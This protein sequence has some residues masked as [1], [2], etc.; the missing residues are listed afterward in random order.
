MSQLFRALLIALL[1]DNF[2]STTRHAANKQQRLRFGTELLNST[3]QLL[4][5]ASA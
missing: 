3:W 5:Q 1:S 4:R 2:T